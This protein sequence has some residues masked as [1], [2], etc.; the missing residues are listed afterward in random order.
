MKKLS[1]L[2]AIL[3]L[4][5][6]ILMAAC[7][8]QKEPDTTTPAQTTPAQTTPEGT[9]PE[10]TTQPEVDPPV[11]HASI[12]VE[13]LAKYEIIYAKNSSAEVVGL[14][15]DLPEL[16]LNTFGAML[17]RRTDL[18][19]EGV[20]AY[21]KGQ[22]E[23]L[24]GQ[25]NREESETFLADLKWD[26]YG[27]G[28]VGD[29]LVIAGK[30]EDG[31]LLALRA[32]VEHLGAKEKGDKV[33]FSN[34]DQLL[35]Q[36][37]YPYPNL[38]IN[39]I[40]ATDLAILCNQEELGGVAQIIRDA[41]IDACG[42]AVPIV[43]DE[44]LGS[45]KNKIVIGHTEMIIIDYAPEEIAYPTGKEFYISKLAGGLFIDAAN[46]S[47]YWSAAAYIA[48]Q[49]SGECGE[50]VVFDQKQYTGEDAI[51]VMSFNLMAG[52]QSNPESKRIDAVV[53]TIL[54]YRP[55]VVGVQE[56]TDT[57]ISLLNQRLGD[58]YTIVGE[59]RNGDGSGEHS[60][61]LYLTE[62]FDCIESGTKWL[63]ETPDKKGSQF[64]ESHYKRI[65]TYALLSRK[66]DSK[67]FLH[68][69]THLDYGSSD[70][71]EAVK[72]A[73]MQV[74]FDEIRDFSPDFII[75]TGDFNATADSPVY[76]MITDKGYKDSCHDAALED[77]T[78][79]GLM[80]TTGEPSHIDFIF[81]ES[82]YHSKYD[83]YYLSNIYDRICTERV[84]NEN[85]SD[86]YPIFAILAIK[87]NEK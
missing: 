50:K 20:D 58:I 14:T 80:G 24:I 72:V 27:F 41:I 3:L 7:N 21:A 1:L 38:T 30:N 57:W 78:Y 64:A 56:A 45:I 68:V 53:E 62:E 18:Y 8:N 47:G 12:S 11:V 61:I 4:L 2:L 85:V 33:F 17:N 69:N 70:A 10:E 86:H 74:I 13:Q 49:L 25:T 44:P 76:Q 63:S 46:A 54:K 55:S 15:N 82:I 51:G 66:S 52:S 59:G 29:K 65:M 28:I 40:S 75:I 79:H 22:Y 31:T 32:F 5:S 60:A 35:V 87:P 26:D 43:K 81:Y 42:I 83:T 73:Q 84:N 6:A 19:Y 9:T 71:E 36:T 48:A 67:Q 37:T 77:P 39:G 34:A 23:I 16:V